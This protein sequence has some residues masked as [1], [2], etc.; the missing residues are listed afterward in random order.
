MAGP[1]LSLT[2]GLCRNLIKR[3]LRENRSNGIDKTYR[4]STSGIHDSYESMPVW[5]PDGAKIAF[6]GLPDG[7]L[8]MFVMNAD[9]SNV[10]A[11]G[12]GSLSSWGG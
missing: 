9:G 4:E 12:P 1:H 2:F 3:L 5:S 7:H 8:E 6:N 11:L 10:T